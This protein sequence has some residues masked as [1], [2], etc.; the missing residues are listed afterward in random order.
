MILFLAIGG[1]TFQNIAIQKVASV[2]PEKPDDYVESLITGTSSAAYKE[3]SE[4]DQKMVVEQ[5]TDA[6]GSVW[7]LFTCAAALSFIL[8]IPLAVGIKCWES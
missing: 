5:V 1:A 6:M 8:S 7:L 4:S 2:L 3:M